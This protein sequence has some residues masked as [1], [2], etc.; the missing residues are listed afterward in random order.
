MS[1]EV[2]F[3]FGD[4]STFVCSATGAQA[5]TITDQVTIID[6]Q[7]TQATGNRTLNLTIN[8]Q[9]KPGARITVFAKTAGTETTIAGT[10][11]TAPT[12]T[13]VA[14]KTRCWEL[15]YDGT[16]FKQVG[17]GVQID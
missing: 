12:S 8:S 16:N 9:V 10:G 3:P 6:A 13:G 11:M 5:I 2:K 4:I 15:V 7:T 17:T 14:G 1:A